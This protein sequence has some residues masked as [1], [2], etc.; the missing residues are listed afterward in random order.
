MC[1]TPLC[2]GEGSFLEVSGDQAPP[3]WRRWAL[4]LLLALSP[5]SC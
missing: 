4:T 3:A 1:L 2:R 5:L